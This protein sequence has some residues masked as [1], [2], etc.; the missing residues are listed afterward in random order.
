MPVVQ[1]FLKKLTANERMAV[2]G[3]AVVTIASI[4]GS[5]WLS[6]L[7]A[8]A[9]IV[10][11]WLK[12]SPTSKVT[13]PA[14]IQLITLAISGIIGLFAL[15][16]LVGALG[17]GSLGG[18]GF[19]FGG[20]FLIYIVAAIA[21][22]V[23]AAMMVLGTWREYQAMPKT[24]SSTTPPASS[25]APMSTPPPPPPVSTP[26]PSTPPPSTPPDSNPPA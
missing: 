9:V 18:L 17:L 23:G 1:E 15:L 21:V 6:L 10:I 14:P 13:W 4:F 11:Y 7:G 26:P 19:G 12:Y 20:M 2:W 25:A 22:A 5:G 3:A 16:G 24:A 8:I